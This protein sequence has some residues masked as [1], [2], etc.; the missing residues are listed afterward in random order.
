MRDV[1]KRKEADDEDLDMEVV[2]FRGLIRYERQLP[3]R[4]VSYYL[5]GELKEPEYYTELF[6]T[7][8]SASETDLIYLH[9]NSPGGD[10]NTGLQ[11]INNIESSSARVVT[12]LEARAYSMAAM[13]FLSGDE[14]YLHDNCQ[15]MF[16]TY[17]GIFAGKGNE[18]QAEIAAVGKW[19][20]KVMHRICAPFLSDAEIDK[21]LTGGDF[22]MDSDEIRRR[23][24]HRLVHASGK[25]PAAKKASATKAGATKNAAAKVSGKKAS[26]KPVAGQT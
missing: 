7:L 15:L 25:R 17:S 19:F 23:M 13:I 21:I 8:R 11:I 24:R 10:F 3:V 4:Q 12:I 2:P 18:Q 22:W 20:G 9:L 26:T 14:M 6:Y 16:H 5:C 1:V